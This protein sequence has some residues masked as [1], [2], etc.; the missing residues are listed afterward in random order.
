MV[1][2]VSG[3]KLKDGEGSTHHM[4]AE[5]VDA[6]RCKINHPRFQSV[7]ICP[8]TELLLATKIDTR[9]PK[10]AVLVF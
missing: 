10:S 6:T 3:H 8:D 4:A 1:A 5:R 7:R 2:V 9:T